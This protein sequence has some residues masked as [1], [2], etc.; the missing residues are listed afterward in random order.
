MTEKEENLVYPNDP[1][2]PWSEEEKARRYEKL[3]PVGK[4]CARFGL[5][6]PWFANWL[7]RIFMWREDRVSL[8]IARDARKGLD[9]EEVRKVDEQRKKRGY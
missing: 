2:E 7:V 4:W 1:I 5:R 6:H 8:K 9:P 3:S